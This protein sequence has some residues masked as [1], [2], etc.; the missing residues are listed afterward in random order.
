[1]WGKRISQ[2]LPFE[3]PKYE[4]DYCGIAHL[5]LNLLLDVRQDEELKDWRNTILS[6]LEN[7][8]V[9]TK[10]FTTRKSY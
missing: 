2:S 4:N 7:Y 6:E 5:D 10:R 1:M 8:V 3:C 9:G